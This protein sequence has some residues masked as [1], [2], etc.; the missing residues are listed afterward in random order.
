MGE[1]LKLWGG[2]WSSVVGEGSYRR[3]GDW[4]EMDWRYFKAVRVYPGHIGISTEWKVFRAF[5]SREGLAAY[6]WS[7]QKWWAGKRLPKSGTKLFKL[8]SKNWFS[9]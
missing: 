6:Y 8:V 3:V 5:S 9:S 2:S 1:N 7:R 4:L